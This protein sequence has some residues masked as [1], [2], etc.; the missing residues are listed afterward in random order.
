MGIKPGIKKGWKS[1]NP[2]GK[3]PTDSQKL[4]IAKLPADLFRKSQIHGNSLE[5]SLWIRGLFTEFPS[6]MNPWACPGLG[7]ADSRDSLV[8]LGIPRSHFREF[9][10]GKF[11]LPGCFPWKQGWIPWIHCCFGS[12]HLQSGSSRFSWIRDPSGIPPQIPTPPKSRWIFP[13][14]AVWEWRG[15]GIWDLFPA[16]IGD[17]CAFGQRVFHDFSWKKNLIWDVLD[18]GKR[19]R[20]TWNSL[21]LEYG[22]ENG[23]GTPHRIRKFPPSAGIPSWNPKKTSAHP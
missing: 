10:P 12:L 4:G 21:A 8:G 18:G 23:D 3:K 13:G 7:S 20:D 19:L 5:F 2:W 17:T 9:S 1:E 22:V 6:G 14:S 15:A 16:G 11:P